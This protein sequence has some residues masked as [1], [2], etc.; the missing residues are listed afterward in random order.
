MAKQ[1]RLVRRGSALFVPNAKGEFV[2]LKT[3]VPNDDLC[4]MSYSFAAE[5]VRTTAACWDWL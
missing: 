4:F 5:R 1:V 3:D 2:E